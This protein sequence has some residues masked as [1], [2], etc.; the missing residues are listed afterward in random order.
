M[1]EI[2]RLYNIVTG[3]ASGN[4][5]RFGLVYFTISLTFVALGG[6]LAVVWGDDNP[7]WEKS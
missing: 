6:L 1:P 5:P 3:R 4:L 7:L 2:I